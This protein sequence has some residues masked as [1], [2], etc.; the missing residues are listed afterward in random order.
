MSELK[1]GGIA[2]Y[3]PTYDPLVA[4]G[5]GHNQ[6]LAP[7]YWAATA[8]ALPPDDG[9][10]TQ[11]IDV[12]VAVIGGGYTGLATAIF[13]AQ[14]H[15]IRATVLEANH[16]GW[17][18]SG[19]NGGQSQNAGGRLSRSQWVAR[20]GVDV[21]RRMHDECTSAYR[22]L[23]ALIRDHHIACDP[24]PGGHLY[25]AHREKYLHKLEAEAR[26]RAEV[27]KYHCEILDGETV[28]RTYLNDAE[29]AGAL[30]EPDGTGVHPLKLVFGCVRV[31][32]ELGAGIRRQ[33]RE[34]LFPGRTQDGREDSR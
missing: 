7:T 23:E 33:R 18:C 16:L 3:D 2:R 25:I 26:V 19:R 30:H 24:Q 5:P 22:T 13:L 9:A 15:G 8:G 29:A 20:W 12:D 34:L 21:A 1:P 11:D 28:R 4:A 17:G 27:F 14:E 6:D 10:L 32:R 31:A